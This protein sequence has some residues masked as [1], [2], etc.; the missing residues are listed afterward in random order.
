MKQ[1]IVLFFC[2]LCL[3]KICFS[4]KTDLHKTDYNYENAINESIKL[5]IES[6]KLPDY[7]YL[8]DRDT[9]YVVI[10]EMNDLH[11]YEQSKI[12]LSGTIKNKQLCFSLKENEIHSIISDS[13][14]Y[15]SIYCEYFDGEIEITLIVQPK[16]SNDYIVIDRGR[17]KV[18]IIDDNGMIIIKSYSRGYG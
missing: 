3:T 17:L 10:K 2:F 5:A 15:L 8:L 7:E 14:R 18:I 16:P 6:K 11:K 4:Q 1:T 12:N 9:I 13:E